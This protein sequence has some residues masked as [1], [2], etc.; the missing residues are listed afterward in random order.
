VL[1]HAILQ[2]RSVYRTIENSQ[3]Y[4][5]K[6]ATTEWCFYVFDTLPLFLAITVYIPFWPGRFLE[7]PIAIDNGETGV[8]SE[9]SER[10]RIE[11]ENEME[12]I[13]PIE[14]EKVDTAGA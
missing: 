6:L 13:S 11:N 2:I 7:F 12:V 10:T 9:T 5:G 8:G 4:H 3:G 1:T 14:K